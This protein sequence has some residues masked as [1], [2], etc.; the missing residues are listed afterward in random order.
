MK[1]RAKRRDSSKVPMTEVARQLFEVLRQKVQQIDAEVIEL[2]ESKSVSYHG[3]AFFLEVL[4][5]SNRVGLL[6]PLDFNEIDDPQGIA[7]DASQWKFLVNAVHDGGVYLR[8]G[9]EADIDKA[10]PMIRL[11]REIAR[12]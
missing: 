1:E 7:E 9:N 4:P 10:L 8:V 11:A 6:L 12:S 5:R 2:A 3:P